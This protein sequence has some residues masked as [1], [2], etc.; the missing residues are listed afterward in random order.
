MIATFHS[1]I[2]SLAYWNNKL[3]PK[4]NASLTLMLILIS[5]AQKL[6]PAFQAIDIVFNITLKI[7][8]MLP[9]S[10]SYQDVVLLLVFKT[11][12]PIDTL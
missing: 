9:L 4:K 12:S 10:N 5:K 11:L 7:K 2:V 8:K 3:K 1:N 6:K